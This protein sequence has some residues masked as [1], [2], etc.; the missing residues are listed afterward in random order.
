MSRCE[1]VVINKQINLCARDAINI[2]LLALQILVPGE[3]MRNHESDVDRL[4]A[5]M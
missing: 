2:F 1:S 5:E 4:R 3:I